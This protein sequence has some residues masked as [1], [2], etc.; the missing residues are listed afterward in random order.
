VSKT[1]DGEGRREMRK[2]SE[3]KGK[4]VNELV[5]RLV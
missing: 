1:R 5:A 4:G 2:L 3:E